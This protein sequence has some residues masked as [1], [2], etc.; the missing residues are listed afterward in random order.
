[1]KLVVDDD[2][3]NSGRARRT[4]T[5]PPTSLPQRNMLDGREE[6][7]MLAEFPAFLS[8]YSGD[9]WDN[10]VLTIVVPRQFKYDGIFLT[11]HRGVIFKVRVESMELELEEEEGDSGG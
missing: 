3:K 1:M 9:R 8:G 4:Q 10:L 7:K 6:G 11:D 2:S 5:I